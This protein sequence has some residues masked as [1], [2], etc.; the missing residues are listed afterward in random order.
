MKARR[1]RSRQ[2]ARNAPVRRG[3]QPAYRHVAV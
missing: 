2:S 1:Q 3:T